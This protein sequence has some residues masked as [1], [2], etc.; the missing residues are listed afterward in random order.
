MNG[1]ALN[2]IVGVAFLVAPL[3]LSS[4]SS[5]LAAGTERDAFSP[6][7]LAEIEEALASLKADATLDESLKSVLRREFEEAGQ[8]LQ[9]AEAFAEQTRAFRETIQSGPR[10][11]E[12]LL[13]QAREI[14]ASGLQRIDRSQPTASLQAELDAARIGLSDLA[15]EGSDAQRQLDALRDRPVKLTSR[16]AELATETSELRAQLEASGTPPETSSLSRDARQTLLRSRLARANAELQML[17]VERRSQSIRE[18]LLRAKIQLLEAR[19]ARLRATVAELEAIVAARLATTA[20]RIRAAAA[21]AKLSMVQTSSE[22]AQTWSE[23]SRS[24]ENSTRS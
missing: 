14:A 22:A 17:D 2:T 5:V 10:Q 9:A 13:R 24:L 23:T 19:V 7:S 15:Q 8:A 16:S 3:V 20:D 4:T 12:A 18:E 6:P 11:V 1:S 21:N